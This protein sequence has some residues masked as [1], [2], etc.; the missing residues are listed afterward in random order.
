VTRS[1]ARERPILPPPAALLVLL[2]GFALTACEGRPGRAVLLISLDTLRQ[3]HL[4]CYGYG[5]NTSPN[6]DRFAREDAVLFE[7]AYAQAPYTLPSHMSIF[8]GLYP[9]AHGV[10]M[11][12]VVDESGEI[13][14]ARLSSRIPTLAE[15]L[16]QQGFTT[17]A[18]TDGLLVKGKYGFDRGFEEY[19]DEYR[20]RHEENGFRKYG[21]AL[22][23]WVRWHSDEDFFL[24][25]HTYDVHEPYVA[26]EPFRSRFAGEPAGREL[27]SA[28]LMYCSL[29]AKHEDRELH[30]YTSLEGLVN[31]YDGGIA[32]VDDELGKLFDLLKREGLWEEALVVITSDHGELFME[33]GL[34]IGH[35]LTLY[36]EETLVPLLIKFPGSAHA[37]KR[38]D[39]IVESVDIMPTVLAALNVPVPA[40]LQ[41]QDLIAGLEEGRWK[42]NH[43][44]GVSP[45]TS[46][47]HY[48]LQDGVKFI[49]AVDD[50]WGNLIRSKF[51]P[52][53]L[54]I[55]VPPPIAEYEQRR[56]MAEWRKLF[57]YDVRLDPLGLTEV[58]HR[59][60]RIYDFQDAE[61]EWKTE[62]IQDREQL[63]KY[64]TNAYALAARST[65]L[66]E[67]YREEGD[68]TEDL[69]AE[70]IEMLEALGY[71]DIADVAGTGA[72][73]G[74]GISP[75]KIHVRPPLTDRTLLNL[76]DYHLWHIIRYLKTTED[77]SLPARFG[78]DIEKARFYFEQF[79]KEHPDRKMWVYWRLN[80]LNV[81]QKNLR[82]E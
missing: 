51:R 72:V 7:A 67:I 20:E 15:V 47:N 33:N 6:I 59:G 30:R 82:R 80:S 34:M 14:V 58:F 62:E 56:D 1:A 65:E 9:E 8:T 57:Y 32:F 63:W 68:A 55:M 75:P 64:K 69:P 60:D 42:K 13:R 18:F 36:N 26:P 46:N 12:R 3:D 49:E 24:F 48:L 52:M 71:V 17:S 53:I 78:R 39:H 5:R 40:D 21:K 2:L 50:P 16:A 28:S 45:H 61:F 23:R 27:P 43:A 10:L 4:G 77:D 19:R 38:V 74:R 22:R 66:S 76:G 37:G 73:S 25:V 11:P 29:L 54:E 35:G 44:F 31:A 81:A 70:D 41:G 79:E